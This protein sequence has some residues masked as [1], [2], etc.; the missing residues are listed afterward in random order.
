ME[1]QETE[2]IVSDVRQGF[3]QEVQ[4][5]DSCFDND[6]NYI[7]LILIFWIECIL[8]KMAIK[9]QSFYFTNFLPP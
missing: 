7:V 3:Q 2:D 1:V 9:S 5:G 4:K 6:S 8:G